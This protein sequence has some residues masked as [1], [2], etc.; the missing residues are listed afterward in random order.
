[1]NVYDNKNILIPLFL[2]LL[3]SVILDTIV[4]FDLYNINLFT[5]IS[6]ITSLISLI[7]LIIIF[8][9]SKKKVIKFT[10]S[11]LVKN[12]LF[13]VING[14]LKK[15]L[16]SIKNKL[17]EDIIKQKKIKSSIK[18]VEDGVHKLDELYDELK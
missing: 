8:K 13:L 1:M 17:G 9:F 3:I 14:H 4:V 10:S 2:I 7:F 12:E 6:Y 5:I 11:E 15:G 16:N 18:N